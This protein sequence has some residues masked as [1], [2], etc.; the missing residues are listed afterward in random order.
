M[1]SGRCR[2]RGLDNTHPPVKKCGQCLFSVLILLLLFLSNIAHMKVPVFEWTLNKEKFTCS[3]M[4]IEQ[5]LR[6]KALSRG[7]QTLHPGFSTWP[8]SLLRGL[9]FLSK[10]EF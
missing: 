3:V 10:Q 8:Q 9:F 2:H 1:G 5:L 4:L 7:T 6:R